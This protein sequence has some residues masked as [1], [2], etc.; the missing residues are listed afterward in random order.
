MAAQILIRILRTALL[1]T[2]PSR[3]GIQICGEPPVARSLIADV[4]PSLSN[5]R[6]PRRHLRRSLCTTRAS[7]DDND[8]DD[9][10]DLAFDSRRD[11]HSAINPPPSSRC[12]HREK[13]TD[14]HNNYFVRLPADFSELRRAGE[15]MI[16]NRRA[17]PRCC[18]PLSRGHPRAA[19]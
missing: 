12:A 17:P 13:E 15:H 10:A 14:A 2:P 9:V 8:D 7:F 1:R 19:R 6:P 18:P 4:L 11:R 3:T 16:Y 5:Q